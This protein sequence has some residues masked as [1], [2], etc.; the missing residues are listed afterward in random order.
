VSLY[1]QKQLETIRIGSSANLYDKIRSLYESFE[2]AI[3]KKRISDFYHVAVKQDVLV[4][5]LGDELASNDVKQI[6]A[7]E[8]NAMAVTN[9][10]KTF[11]LTPG[12]TNN[13]YVF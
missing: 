3:E 5:V 8:L 12:Y 11:Y 1:S 9:S 7:S 4:S 10:S 13:E 6:V 2:E